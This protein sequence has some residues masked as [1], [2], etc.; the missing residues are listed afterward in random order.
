[1]TRLKMI[2]HGETNWNEKT[3]NKVGMINRL[4]PRVKF[5]PSLLPTTSNQNTKLNM[6]GHLH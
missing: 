3:V 6:S 2:R 1:M 4:M 5:R